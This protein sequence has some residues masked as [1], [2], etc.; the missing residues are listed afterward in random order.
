MNLNAPDIGSV[1]PV[2]LSGDPNLFKALFSFRVRDGHS[3]KENFLT[4]A[5]VYVLKR[6]PTAMREWVRLL[7]SGQVS[8]S[9]VEINT[10]LTHIDDENYSSIYPD[11][12]VSG[13][14]IEENK[15]NLVV[16]HKW[17]SPCSLLQ[18]KRYAKLRKA[19]ERSFLAFVCASA[20]EKKV[21]DRFPKTDF[22]GLSYKAVLWRDVYRILCSIS[23][24]DR[25]IEE[26]LYFMNMEGL[27][28]GRAITVL[29]MQAFIAARGFK[30]QLDRYCQ[31]L[32]NEYEW[33]CIPQKYHYAPKVHDAWGRTAIVF[34]ESTWKPAIAIGF[35]YDP[36]DHGVQLINPE[37]G[38]DLAIRVH[39]NPAN[40]SP[41]K[42]LELLEQRAGELRKQGAVVHTKNQP[43]NNNKHTLI[44]VRRS[45]GDVLLETATEDEQI[46]AIYAQLEKWCLTLFADPKLLDAFA[47]LKP[48]R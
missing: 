9:S 28:P 29:E 22:D 36:T 34:S 6:N 25:L 40:S 32:L 27:G 20:H 7:T 30:G 47:A 31:R 13:Y 2:P 35:L 46:E 37:K 15:F 24:K 48:Y 12:H 8:A 18:L 14:D 3:P 42:M 23:T 11:V 17:D 44:L 38:I 33:N 45:L 41:T 16:E 10:R 1:T 43:G 4:E 26:F 5:L 21:A 39:A 19:G